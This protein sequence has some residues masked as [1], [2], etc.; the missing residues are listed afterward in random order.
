MLEKSY[1]FCGKSLQSPFLKRKVSRKRRKAVEDFEMV[2]KQHWL[3]FR[4]LVCDLNS[5]R[6]E[7]KALQAYSQLFGT[8]IL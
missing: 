6:K 2:D 3:S 4:L 7:S 5:Q 8:N 1:L